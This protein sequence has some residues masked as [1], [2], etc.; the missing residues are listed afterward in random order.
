ML[1]QHS[2]SF[3]TTQRSKQSLPRNQ[4]VSK[5]TCQ[6]KQ[7]VISPTW[8]QS[9]HNQPWLSTNSCTIGARH[10]WS[11]SCHIWCSS[12]S[13]VA[14][15]L[16]FES[17][18]QWELL[19]WCCICKPPCKWNHTHWCIHKQYTLL[20]PPVP[21]LYSWQNKASVL[22]QALPQYPSHD[23][24]LQ[25]VSSLLE[26]YLKHPSV[27]QPL[28]SSCQQLSWPFPSPLWL[29]SA[30]SSASQVCSSEK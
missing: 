5:L 13:N 18:Q 11:F 12:H 9:F 25:V 14:R 23:V 20:Q 10:L 24:G 29:L 7:R 16:C 15:K 2:Q 27:Q 26:P 8:N 22:G 19:S 4:C 6:G 1:G 30:S 28:L 21:P 3:P 17:C